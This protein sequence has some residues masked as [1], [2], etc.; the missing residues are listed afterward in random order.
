M[1]NQEHE[2]TLNVWL[3]ELLKDRG[4]VARQER[5]QAKGKRVDVEIRLGTVKIALEA[6]QG[7]RPS[8]RR[9]AIRSADGRF[10]EA[11]ADCALAVCYPEGITEKEELIEARMIWTIRNPANLAVANTAMWTKGTLD[12]LVPA[13]RQAPMQLGN[14]DKAAAG[15]SASLNAAVERLSENQKEEIARALDLPQGKSTRLSKGRTSKWNQAAKRAMLVLATAVMFHSRLDNYR[16]ELKPEFDNREPEG[17]PFTGQWPPQMAQQ[18]VKDNDPTQEFYKAWDLWL[19]VDY[20]PIFATA[21]TALNGCPHDHAFTEAIKE[22]AEAAL[23]LTRDISGL[24]HDLL[25]RIFHTV[26]D[27]ARYDG[28]FYTSTPAATMLATLAI[29]EETCDFNDPKAISNLRI[30]DP[31]CGTGTLLMTAGERVRELIGEHGLTPETNKTIIEQV[32]RGYDVNLTATHMAAT[33]LGL[34]SPTTTFKNMKIGRALLGVDERGNTHLGSLEFLGNRGAPRLMAWPTAVTQ[35]DTQEEINQAEPADVV[36]MNPPFTRDSLRHDQ[37]SRAE[38]KKLK[39]REKALFKNK[40]TYLAGQSGAFLFL[41]EYFCRAN[42][43]TLAAVIPL[44]STTDASGLGIRR[45][46]AQ[47]FLIE[48]IIASQDPERM[49]F[50][51]NTEIG[52]ALLICR[53]WPE[54]KGAKPPT[55]IVNLVRNP[56]TPAEARTV[57]QIIEADQADSE[58]YGTV[59]KWPTDRI[60]AGDWSGVQFLQPYLSRQF[61]NLKNGELFQV[62]TLKNIAEVG[63]EGRRVRDAFMKSEIPDELGRTALWDHDTENT[64]SMAAKTDSHIRPKEEKRH[65]ADKYWEQRSRLLLPNRV[66]LNTVRT[67]CVRLPHAA[68]GSAWSPCRFKITGANSEVLEKALSVFLNSSIGILVMAGS[69]T[70]KDISYPRFSLVDL[71]DLT[72][73]D[74]RILDGESTERLAKEYEVQAAKVLKPLPQMDACNVRKALDHAVIEALGI[75][76]D[77]TETIRRN[78][79]SEPA[80]TGKRYGS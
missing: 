39:D 69:R 1:P 18:C 26:L 2:Q 8:N 35:I 58:G 30:T 45:Y 15:L 16:V 12:D 19:A 48:T 42:K 55:R 62:T 44:T 4:I 56:S 31:A 21:Q 14:P 11:N 10:K 74:F 63:P 65:L 52:E 68:V 79:A 50:S 75:D 36:I 25:G 60:E 6:K 32:L 66:R 73:P 28:S 20:K 43:G 49:Y 76:R 61:A 59:Q 72:V 67:V 53:R 71:R 23:T 3:A 80:I 64:Q 29:N 34:L 54:G 46:L 9:D 77:Q 7:Q 57:A 38:E 13:I 33:T 22:T 27:T 41:G 37:F 78:L 47:H 24:R 51:E 70:G 17:T 40:P 5:T